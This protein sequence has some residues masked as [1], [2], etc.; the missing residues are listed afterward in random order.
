MA[1]DLCITY[2][3]ES[4][5]SIQSKYR[6]HNKVPTENIKKEY[7]RIGTS[8][9]CVWCPVTRSP[10]TIHPTLHIS[11]SIPKCSKFCFIIFSK[12]VQV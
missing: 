11:S 4:I 2:V 1:V 12:F 7:I 6:Q 3:P 9:K 5:N 8:I 10:T